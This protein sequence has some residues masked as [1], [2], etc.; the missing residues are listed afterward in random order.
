M[1]V[2]RVR[3]LDAGSDLGSVTSVCRAMRGV[4]QSC[5]DDPV[6]TALQQQERDPLGAMPTSSR[7]WAPGDCSLREMQYLAPVVAV[8][9]NGA[10][11]VSTAGRNLSVSVV[12]LALAC[13]AW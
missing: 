2:C 5:R 13:R 7:K 3:N 9:S 4:M 8:G 1:R 12:H 11:E 6:A 10:S